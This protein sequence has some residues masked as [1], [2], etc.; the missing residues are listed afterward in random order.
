MVRVELQAMNQGV[1]A[2]TPTCPHCGTEDGTLG[3]SN[4]YFIC[5][6]PECY[7]ERR[8]EWPRGWTLEVYW[9]G[10]GRHPNEQGK[11]WRDAVLASP[12]GR[13]GSGKHFF[14]DEP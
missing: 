10:D 4:A 8:K 6:N 5:R 11:E 2:M 12:F 1:F 13:E 9:L 3:T 7:P 14:E